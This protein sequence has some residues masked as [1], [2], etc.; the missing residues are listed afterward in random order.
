MSKQ[1][2]AIE[3]FRELHE[4]GCFV[5][6]NP[7][8]IGSAVYLA[9]AGFR[10]LATTSAGFAFTK[11]LADG[12]VSREMMLDH[13]REISAVTDLPVNADFLNGYA[14]EPEAVAE[15]VKLC[16]A[17]GVAGLSIEDSTGDSAKPLYDFDLAVE[18]IKAARAA[19]Q[20]VPQTK[21]VVPEPGAITTESG[22]LNVILTARCE[23]YLVGDS[24]PLRTSLKR[25]VAFADAGA[26][27]L[28]APGVTKPEE[29]VEIVRAVSPKPI[30]VLVFAQNCELTI[31]QLRDIGV[32]R[33][34]VGS[35]LA[36]AAWGGLI[37][38]AEEIQTSGSFQ[39]FAD[40]ATFELNSLFRDTPR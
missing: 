28:Y 3:K 4:Q 38:A 9:H 14:D 2:L 25:L 15:N 17:T 34:S 20:S 13:F 36:R 19:I 23:A 35:T 30:N 22:A 1:S 10:A 24:D 27:C 7:W 16:V 32:R 11:G 12:F 33:I 5:L 26:D 8:D 31:N 39:S 21:A 6:P 29:I 37:R 40:A 18:R